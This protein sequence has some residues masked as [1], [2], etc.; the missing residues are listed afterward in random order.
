MGWGIAEFATMINTVAIC[1]WAFACTKY[2]TNF[3]EDAYANDCFP[4]NQGEI[5]VLI[6]LFRTL[7][8]FAVAYFQVPWA[9]KNGAL[10]TFGCEAAYAL[11]SSIIWTKLTRVY[12][13]VT[14]LFLIVV[15]FTQWKGKSLRVCSSSSQ[16]HLLSTHCSGSLFSLRNERP[17]DYYYPLV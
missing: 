2:H 9:T 6:N 3:L 7:G 14:G 15:P 13:I 5:S 16:G 1:R 17:R 12:S 10:Q 8:G 4:K 11:P